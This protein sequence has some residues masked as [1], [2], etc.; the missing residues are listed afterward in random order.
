MSISV[1][2]RVDRNVS[3]VPHLGQ[4][5]RVPWSEDENSEDSPEVKANSVAGTVNQDTNG[6]ALVRRQIEQWQFVSWV[7]VPP[8]R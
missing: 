3:G 5:V 2:D 7:G 6:A 8:A 4:K 1:G